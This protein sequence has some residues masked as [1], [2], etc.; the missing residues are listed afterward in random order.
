MS[1]KTPLIFVVDDDHDVLEIHEVV[2]RSGGYAV[3]TF[4]DPEKAIAAMAE[5]APDLFVTDLMMGH[6]DSGF[7]LAR[8]LKSDPATSRI[9]VILVTAVAARPGFDFRPKSEADLAAMAVDAYFDKPADHDALL[10]KVRELLNVATSAGG[11]S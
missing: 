6:L 4:D 7:S 3:R 1:T 5:A 11:A 10:A 2:L 8:A 9:P